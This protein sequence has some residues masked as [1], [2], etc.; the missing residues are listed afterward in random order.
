MYKGLKGRRPASDDDLKIQNVK[1]H[2]IHW[3]HLS[4]ML[5]LSYNKDNLNIFIVEY[6][7][8]H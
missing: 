3:W 2:S 7:S 1:Y 5:K 4:Q 8:I 6:L